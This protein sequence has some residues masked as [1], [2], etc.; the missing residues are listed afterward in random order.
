[1]VETAPQVDDGMVDSMLINSG[2]GMSENR[3]IRAWAA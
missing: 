2:C 1:V 3:D